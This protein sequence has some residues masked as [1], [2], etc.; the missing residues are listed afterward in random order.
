MREPCKECPWI[1][2]NSHN[3]KFRIYS[4]K[5]KEHGYNQ[6]CHMITKDIWGNDIPINE[7]TE[8]V[9]YKLCIKK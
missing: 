4:E 7:K 8:C 1:Q 9:G 3:L 5:M 6:A 2:E